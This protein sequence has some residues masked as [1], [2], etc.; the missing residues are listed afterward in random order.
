MRGRPRWYDRRG[1]ATFTLQITSMVDMFTLLLVFLLKTYSSSAVEITVD[2]DLNLPYS[3]SAKEPKEVLK[4]VVSKTGIFVDTKEVVHFENGQIT[5]DMLD[6]KDNQFIRP[7]YEALDVEAKKSR[8]IAQVNDTVQFDGTVLMQ[9]E[10]SLDYGLL[11]KVLYTA[12]M[13]GYADLKFAV[14]AQE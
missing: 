1:D 14:I 10:K 8:D 4:L 3:V 13:A 6:Q 5:A 12:S 11:K 7:L 2:K 9:A